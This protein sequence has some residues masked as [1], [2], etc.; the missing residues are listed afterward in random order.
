MWT[1]ENVPSDPMV[2]AKE[3]LK[4]NVEN[5]NWIILVTYDIEKDEFKRKV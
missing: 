3:T 2:W 4:Q 5:A 1:T